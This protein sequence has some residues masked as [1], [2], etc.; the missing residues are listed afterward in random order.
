M[1]PALEQAWHTHGY[2]GSV[3]HNV[4][5]IY[6]RYLG[7]YDGNPAHLWQHPPEAAATRYVQAIGGLDATIA[8]AREFAD[9]GDLR[10]AAE[11][12]SHAAFAD[13][14]SQAAKTLLAEVFT[15]LGHGC[16]CATWRNNYLTG[17]QELR[18]SIADNKVSSAGMIAALTIT[19][20]FDSLAIRI[21]GKRA[22]DTTASIRWHFTDTAENYRMELSN[23]AL[24]HHLT[25]RT[26]P[27][28]LTVTL[29]RPQLLTMLGG[30]GTNGVQFDGD[31]AI[32]TTITGLTDQPDPAFPIVTP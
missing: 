28:D 7:W 3:S 8:S 15:R 21:D 18:G 10:F 25:S 27:A 9:A 11:L 17:A 4:K 29:T 2:Y 1:P 6:Q 31:P 23:G 14:S 24:T 13:P 20:L 12:A 22:W 19:Q 26:E 5:A 32:F 30:A 16:E